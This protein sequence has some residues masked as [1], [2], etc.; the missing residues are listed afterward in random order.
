[1][2]NDLEIEV[3][4]YAQCSDKCVRVAIRHM[5]WNFRI[6]KDQDLNDLEI[7]NDCVVNRFL[8]Y[9][10]FRFQAEPTPISSSLKILIIRNQNN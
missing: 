6:K 8:K 2:I 5:N 1:M 9:D 4:S 7:L 10:F 3:E